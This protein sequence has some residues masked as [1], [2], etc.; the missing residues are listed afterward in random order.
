MK[1]SLLDYIVCP[2]CCSNFELVNPITEDGEII[3]ASLIC[4]AGH[5][6]PVSKGVPRLLIEDQLSDAQKQVKDSFSEKWQDIPDYGYTDET[7]RFHSEW[8]LQRYGWETPENLADFLCTRCFVLDAG[9]GLGRDTRFYAEHTE[10]EVFGV[11]ISQSIDIAYQHN[12][13]LPNAHLIQA[14]LMRLPFRNGFFDFIASD[15]VLH[16]TPDTESAF[17]SLIPLLKEGGQVAIYVYKK[18]GPIREFCDDYIR[19]FTTKLSP[20]ECYK[21]SQA[22]TKLGKSLSDM[23]TELVV[24]ED[25]PFLEI[26][27]GKYNLQRFIYWNVFKC[28]WNDEQDFETNVMTNFDWY[29]PQ[30]AWRHT[31]EEV[32]GWFEELNMEI[33]SF[34]M[35]ESGISVRGS[36]CAA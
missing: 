22:I 4:E 33:L 29:H 1:K 32:K 34:N 25:V 24:P 7:K 10:G 3:S 15:F 18:K 35:V 16:H 12:G 21:F 17:K 2:S 19:S 14:D 9:T 13:H 23:N 5:S 30:Y 27:A 36:K 20:E 8:Y 28:F 6:F 11:D 26:K 31:P